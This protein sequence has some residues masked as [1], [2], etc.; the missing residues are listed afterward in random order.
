M[1]DTRDDTDCSGVLVNG[2]MTAGDHPRRKNESVR[3][4][5]PTLDGRWEARLRALGAR[6]RKHEEEQEAREKAAAMAAVATHGDSVT[7]QSASTGDDV[8][9]G[10]D[11]GS[12]PSKNDATGARAATANSLGKRSGQP[13]GVG[14]AGGDAAPA[15][16]SHDAGDDPTEYFYTVDKWGHELKQPITFEQFN[17]ALSD[18]VAALTGADHVDKIAMRSVDADGTLKP[19]TIDYGFDSDGYP[20]IIIGD[21][22][23][24]PVLADADSPKTDSGLLLEQPAEGTSADDGDDGPH[25]ELEDVIACAGVIAS[26]STPAEIARANDV[27]KNDA[28]LWRA[29]NIAVG[30]LDDEHNDYD[31]IEEAAEAA[32]KML[33]ERG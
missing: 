26:M 4:P 25:V 14:A 18:A 12:T 19:L 29:A 21:R 33:A 11:A 6:L 16:G 23:S 31:E 17:K 2:G 20:F 24:M 5:E 10:P 7:V 9:A 8:A 1:A 27:R 30:L 3:P 15:R 22:G 13:I 32:I 28:A